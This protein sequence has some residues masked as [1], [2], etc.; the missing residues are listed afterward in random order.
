MSAQ[1]TQRPFGPALEITCPTWCTV[2]LAQH[3]ADFGEYG[4][5]A[6]HQSKEI[7]GVFHSR[8]A[9]ADNTIDP[10][11]PP[12]VFLDGNYADGLTLER[13][14]AIAHRILSAV[15]EARDV[16]TMHIPGGCSVRPESSE[17]MT[18]S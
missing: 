12:L 15:K 3:M 2:A 5:C 8:A 7:D 14:E 17:G 18:R 13:A 10:T 6:I 4:G 9:L 1:R 11:D 16:H